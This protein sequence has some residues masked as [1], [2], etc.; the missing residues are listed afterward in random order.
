MTH[1]TGTLSVFDVIVVDFCTEEG[2]EE[3][4]TGFE[5]EEYGKEEE[6]EEEVTEAVAVRLSTCEQQCS[7]PYIAHISSNSTTA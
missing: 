6:A 4:E 3:L 2:R 1:T 7:E 5:V